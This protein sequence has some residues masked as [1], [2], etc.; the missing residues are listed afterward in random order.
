MD[1]VHVARHKV[2]VEGVSVRRVAAELGVSRNTVR[3]YLDLAQPVYG[4]RQAQPR[5]VMD[6]V[7]PRIEALLAEAPRWTGGKQRLTASRLHQMLLAEGLKVGVT[8]VRETVAEWKRRRREV[9]VPLVYHPGDLAEVDFFEVLVDLGGVRRKAWMLVVRL[10]HSGRDYARI[11]PRQDQVCFLDGHVR[12][13][14]HF[15]AVP[16]RL[17][18]DNLKAAVAKI[19]VGCGP[20]A[21]IALRRD[22]VALLVRGEL[23]PTTHRSR[24]GRRGGTRQGHS[25]AASRADPVRQGPRRDQQCPAG[26]TRRSC[27]RALRRRARWNAATAATRL[28]R[29]SHALAVRLATVADHRRG[30]D[31]LGAVLLGRGWMSPPTS[32]RTT[33]RWSGQR[34]PS[35]IRGCV[36]ASDPS[37]TATI[38]Q[39]WPA[40]LRRSVRWPPSWC[41]TWALHSM[42]PGGFSS[43]GTGPS[44]RLAS[45]RRCWATSRHVA[46]PS[47]PKRSR[48]LSCAR[49]RCSWR[50]RHLRHP[51]RCWTRRRCR[52]ASEP[53]R[54]RPGVRRTTMCSW[55]EGRDDPDRRRQG[56]G[57]GADSGPQDARR[58]SCVRGVGPPGSRRALE[59]RGVPARGARRRADVSPG[60]GRAPAA[61]RRPLPRGQDARHLR[62]HRQRGQC[63]RGSGNRAGAWGLA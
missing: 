37:T 7:G 36:W 31:L 1:Q 51:T 8:L 49:S 33:W 47:W 41:A 9:F 12:A 32:G 17:A 42:Q 59:P 20:Q 13:F 57:A 56:H 3:R 48:M 15:G 43:T 55:P 63:D 61:A 30:C 54:S 14:A 60:L 4:P 28:P 21:H 50:W 19:L 26:T 46:S 52:T 24:Q 53:W 35:S 2:L 39:S 58:R 29:T 10:M 6:R 5:P 27:R 22:D 62:L 40:S 11:Y 23:L 44:R 16:Q 34:A 18:Y 38:C 45:S 25:P